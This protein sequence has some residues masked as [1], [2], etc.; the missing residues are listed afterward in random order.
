MRHV[1]IGVLAKRQGHLLE[2]LDASPAS[3]CVVHRL[4]GSAFCTPA[5]VGVSLAWM[6]NGSIGKGLHWERD[7]SSGA[8]CRCLRRQNNG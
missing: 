2:K 7:Y 6:A 3:G 5:S 1:E 4:C 8:S